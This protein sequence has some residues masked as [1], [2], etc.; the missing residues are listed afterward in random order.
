MKSNEVRC[1]CH[2]NVHVTILQASFWVKKLLILNHTM[3]R[4][5]QPGLLLVHSYWKTIYYYFMLHLQ[6][7]ACKST[8]FGHLTRA[9]CHI[10]N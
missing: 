9:L 8:F 2:Y 5:A 10:G 3:V 7:L 4:V 6:V 1:N